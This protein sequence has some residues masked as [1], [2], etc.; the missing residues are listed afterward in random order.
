MPQ[1]GHF[2]SSAS[3]TRENNEAGACIESLKVGVKRVSG[4]TVVRSPQSV[5]CGTLD[6]WPRR[7]KIRAIA[8]KSAVVRKNIRIFVLAS[9]NVSLPPTRQVKCEGSFYPF[10]T[11]LGS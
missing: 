7:R 9:K 8:K 6:P 11:F 5:T 10:H 4:F 1:I 2:L 3:A